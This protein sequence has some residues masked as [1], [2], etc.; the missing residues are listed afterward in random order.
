MQV[1]PGIVWRSG[2]R[3]GE[4]PASF[5]HRGIVPGKSRRRS[6]IGESCRG[7]PVVVRPSGNHSGQSPASLG[8]RGIIPGNFRRESRR[9]ESF[10]GN[11]SNIRETGDPSR[12]GAA[13]RP[14]G[15]RIARHIR[16]QPQQMTSLCL[17]RNA[18]TARIGDAFPGHRNR[19]LT[20]IPNPL[21]PL[22]YATA[23]FLQSHTHPFGD[24][25][26]VP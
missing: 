1:V 20:P 11:L 10:R 6:A 22:Q 14:P 16:T 8:D 12:E 7:N 4:S 23:K 13:V 9:R 5:G 25:A 15:T 3:S 18:A 19:E 2:S 24:F 17:A 21:P 26:R